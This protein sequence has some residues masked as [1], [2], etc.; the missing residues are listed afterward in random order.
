M[1]PHINPATGVWD[2]NYF[3]NRGSTGGVLGD[4]NSDQLA[5][6]NRY[7]EDLKATAKQNYDF[8]VK[9][10]KQQH[11]AALGTNDTAKAQF[12]EKVASTYEKQVGRIPFDYETKTA[13]EKEDIANYLKSSEI[14]R[15]DQAARQGEFQAQDKFNSQQE[16]QAN[17]ESAN[18]RGLL[19]SGIQDKEANRLKLARQ[20]FTEDPFY[21]SMNLETTQRNEADRLRQIQSDRNLF[22]ITTGARR[23]AEDI[24]TA[25]DKGNEAATV[26]LNTA[27]K[28]ADIIAEQ[29]KREALLLLGSNGI[30]NV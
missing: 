19:G 29:K 17:K 11:D 26:D 18:A 30:N 8:V 5:S 21:R 28:N 14:A 27:N 20:L 9:Y 10:L 16:Q 13:R 15:Q 7:V 12:L 1:D 23:G 25:T 3:A 4:I 24:Q 6:I 2:D 22:D